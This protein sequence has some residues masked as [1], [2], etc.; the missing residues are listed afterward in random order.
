M[1]T[2]EVSPIYRQNADVGGTSTLRGA[3]TIT[4]C[5]E[6][7]HFLKLK[8]QECGGTGGS[9]RFEFPMSSLEPGADTGLGQPAKRSFFRA[10]CT[11]LRFRL[12]L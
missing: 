10:D 1:S 5:Q 7:W 3:E 8:E 11:T 2:S 6:P 9:V 12:L 4:S